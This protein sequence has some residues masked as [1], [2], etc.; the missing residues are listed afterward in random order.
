MNEL[1][2]VKN[3]PADKRMHHRKD[4]VQS[5]HPELFLHEERFEKLIE[6]LVDVGWHS[7]GNSPSF[8]GE[9]SRRDAA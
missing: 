7:R 1:K 5:A 2:S 4:A 3:R 9:R 6:L 8:H